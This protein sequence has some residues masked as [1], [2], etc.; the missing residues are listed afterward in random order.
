MKKEK[1][2]SPSDTGGEESDKKCSEMAAPDDT[3][4]EDQKDRVTIS[5]TKSE[6]E[7][8]GLSR[9]ESKPEV[10]S[11][12]PEEFEKVTNKAKERDLYRDELLRARADF[13]N[14]QKRVSRDRPQVEEQAVR[15]LVIELLPVLDNF[16]RALAADGSPLEDFRRGIEMVSEMLQKALANHGIEEIDAMGKPFDPLLHEAVTHEETELFP[17]DTVSEVLQK[18]YTQNGSV[19][20]AARVKVA[21]AP[22]EVQIP[23]PE[24]IPKGEGE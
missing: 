16:E 5:E 4:P 11:L 22:A 18:G 15:R 8:S 19:V 6:Q 24:D 21:K 12:S 13:A 1:Q 20:R 10:L 23:T 14:Y 17:P 9:A 3:G 7:A 2:I